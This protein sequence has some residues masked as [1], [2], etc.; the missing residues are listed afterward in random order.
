MAN[1]VE[2]GVVLK[3]LGL[4]T[5]TTED[6]NIELI[7]NAVE[8]W[9][10]KVYCQVDLVSTQH[11]E[12]YDG[13]GTSA[14]CLNHYPVISLNRLAIGTEDAISVKNTNDGAHASVSVSSTTVTL[15]KDGTSS[16]LALATYS[17]MTTLVAAINAVSGW[18]AALVDTSFGSYPSTELLEKFGLQCINDNEVYL[19]MPDEAEESFEVDARTGIVSSVYGFGDGVRS[20]YVD[21]TA[22]YATIPDDLQ[23]AT[24]ILIK[25]VYQRRSEESFG[26]KNYSVSGMSVTFEEGLPDQVVQILNRYRR[27]II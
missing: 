14:F 6:P 7:R 20:V 10:Q 22:G 16:A 4:E 21:Y 5:L 19:V 24:L 12:K 3:F 2:M 23:L 8:S 18:S 15:F 9:I 25:N 27:I 17:T 1:L 13:S 26:A 11:K